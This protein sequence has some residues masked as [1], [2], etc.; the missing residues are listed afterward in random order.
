[1]PLIV[2][3]YYLD[4]TLVSLTHT[5]Q[6]LVSEGVVNTANEEPERP[7][8]LKAEVQDKVCQQHQRPDH[9]KLQVQERTETKKKRFYYQTIQ[10]WEAWVGGGGCNHCLAFSNAACSE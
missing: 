7:K 8:V 4:E 10:S 9:Q 1:M 2:Q 3:S 5:H 6:A